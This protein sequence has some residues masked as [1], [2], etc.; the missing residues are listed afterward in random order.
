M[1]DISPS[2]VP[3]RLDQDT[4]LV[5][6]DFGWIGRV[7]RETDVESTDRDTIV[8]ALARGEFNKPVRIVAFN[9]AECWSSDVTMDIAEELQ[10]AIGVVQSGVQGSGRQANRIRAASLRCSVAVTS[11]SS[12]RSS[13]VVRVSRSARAWSRMRGSTSSASLSLR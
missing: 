10:S 7:W 12:S 2:I 6:D 3:E 5:V 8:G 13:A 9:T 11:N 1:S 4:Y